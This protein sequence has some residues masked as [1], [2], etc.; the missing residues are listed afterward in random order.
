MP[1]ELRTLAAAAVAVCTLVAAVCALAVAAEAF[2]PVVAEAFAPVAAGAF[3]LV[4]AVVFAPAAVAPV[5]LRDRRYRVPTLVRILVAMSRARLFAMPAT[6]PWPLAP[7]Q[8][9]QGSM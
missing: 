5:S 7:R 8:Q 1:V 6:D 2:A 4:A 9:Q 3:A